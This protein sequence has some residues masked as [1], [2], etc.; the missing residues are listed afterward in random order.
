MESWGRGKG[1]GCEW[2]C[3][4]EWGESARA[5]LI[6]FMCWSAT[7]SS[8]CIEGLEVDDRPRLVLDF[9]FRVLGVRVPNGFV[10][11]LKVAVPDWSNV[12]EWWELPLSHELRAM[13]WGGSRKRRSRSSRRLVISVSVSFTKSW[14]AGAAPDA[15]DTAFWIGRSRVPE[16]G[17]SASPLFS[18]SLLKCLWKAVLSSVIDAQ[19][20]YCL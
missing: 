5:W 2:S 12:K 17:K 1:R 16:R 20:T 19:A 13:W 15:S 3:E 4:L 9:P 8:I 11:D 18:P 7:F 10:L 6:F 14:W